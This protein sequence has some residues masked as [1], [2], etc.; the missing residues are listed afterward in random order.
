M[1]PAGDR[2]VVVIS[3]GSRGLGMAIASR[4]LDEGYIVATYSR[5]ASPF[6]KEQ[7]EL[8]PNRKKFFWSEVDAT[9]L[10]G[11]KRFVTEASERYGEIG[12]LVNNAGIGTE[13]IFASM[14][15]S[16]IELCI[17]VNLKATL[18]LTWFCS[19]FMIQRRGGCIINI[20]SIAGIRGHSGVVVYSA[21]KAGL[22]GLTRSLARELG[23]RGI[24]V[25]SVAPGYFESEMVNGLDEAAKARIARRTPLGRLATVDDI[26]Q[27]VL[28]MMS[29]S[30]SFIT[31]QT[32]VVD[33]GLT[34]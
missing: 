13:G 14:R 6:V 23:P 12:A 33:G 30:A 3:G 15:L 20:S 21:T 9:D 34:C 11:V 7:M 27:V 25:N 2:I 19:R 32:I 24:R 28:F 8:D 5:S 16:D 4:C 31:G 18:Y 22:D 29:P 17:D 10:Q 26:V 1:R